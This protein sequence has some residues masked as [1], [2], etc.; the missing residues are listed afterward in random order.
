M[1]NTQSITPQEHSRISGSYVDI[2]RRCPH[3]IPKDYVSNQ[4]ETEQI[5]IGNELH[6]IVASDLLKNLGK[7]CEEPVITILDD[8]LIEVAHNTASIVWNEYKKVKKNDKDAILVVEERLDLTGLLSVDEP[9]WSY[10]DSA[11]ISKGAIKVFD[12][13]AGRILISAKDELITDRNYGNP[14]ESCYAWSLWNKYKDDGKHNFKKIELSILQLRFN[15]ISNH[16]M[17][18][19]QLLDWADYIRPL[20][21]AA[22]KGEGAYNPNPLCKWCRNSAKCRAYS[23]T[24][25]S[26]IELMKN[27]E[28]LTD[29]DINYLI[30]KVKDFKTWCDAVMN[31]AIA[32]SVN[33]GKKWDGYTLSNGRP[34][35]VYSDESKVKEVA[36]SSGN[37]DIIVETILTPAQA[38]KVV[39]KVKFKEVFGSLVTYKEGKPTLVPD[40]TIKEKSNAKEEFK[41][42]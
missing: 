8:E 27:P 31:Y 38:E 41:G 1:N 14:Q 39:G 21:I 32:R 34:T 17:T 33:D 36:I 26:E 13:K 11:I 37:K 23:V 15:H 24:Q 12:Y 10:C 28:D 4:E 25:L 7:Q 6:A 20:S 19:K 42:E 40:G 22:L 5:K 35:R 9:S 30:P 29:E 16:K 3:T 2:A 18:V